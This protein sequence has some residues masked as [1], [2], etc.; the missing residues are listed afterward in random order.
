MYAVIETGGK[1]YRVSPGQVIKVEKLPQDAGASLD[2]DNVL[3]VADGETH[4]IGT[5]Y[6]K[7]SKVTASVV[8]HGKH[9]K[10]NII[11]FHRRKHHMKHQGHRQNFTAI[12][13]TEISMAGKKVSK[14]AA[15]KK[16]EPAAEEKQAVVTQQAVATQSED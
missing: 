4:T 2:F 1:Q 9:K 10:I 15:T 5:P 14:A 13:I 16:V 12:E 11:K 6:V 3:M 8:E 7:D